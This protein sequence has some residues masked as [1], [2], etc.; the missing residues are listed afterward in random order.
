MEK[1]KNVTMSQEQFDQVK[2]MVGSHLYNLK[3]EV[4]KIIQ[5]KA[6]NDYVSNDRIMDYVNSAV[7]AQKVY[8]SLWKMDY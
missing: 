3:R 8:D 1:E 6:K 4:E 7:E 5:E 2:D